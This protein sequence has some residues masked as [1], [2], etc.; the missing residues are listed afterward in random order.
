MNNLGF[1]IGIAI[2]LAIGI[3]NRFEAKP[4]AIAKALPT[5]TFVGLSGYFRKGIGIKTQSLAGIHKRT[6]FQLKNDI[7]SLPGNSW[8]SP[9]C[10]RIASLPL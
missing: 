7:S 4:I 3:G 2:A 1:G 10:P 9:R 5:P 8:S 6:T